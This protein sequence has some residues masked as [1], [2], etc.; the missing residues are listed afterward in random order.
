MK[1]LM[2]LMLGMSSVLASPAMFAQEK[3]ED[4]TKRT[5]GKKTVKSNKN[6][7]KQ[8]KKRAL[9]FDDGSKKST[10]APAKGEK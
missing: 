2:A 6:E 1:T 10:P 8:E 7:K 5:T 4:A 9:P 3:K